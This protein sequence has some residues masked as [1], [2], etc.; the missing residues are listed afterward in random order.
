M[1]F[2]VPLEANDAAND[3]DPRIGGKARS[4][5][6]L[7]AAGL[8]VPRAFAITTD[9]F[10]RLRAG[11]PPL[12]AALDGDAALAAVDDAVAA[13]HAAA[14]PAGFARELADA[15]AGLAP[16]TSFSIRSS[17]E[18]EDHAD[19]LGAGI[20]LSRTDVP[21]SDVLPAVR[22]VLAAALAPAA[23]AYVA[24]RAQGD[25][26]SMAVLVHPFVPG[27]AS[28]TAAF[29][30]GPGDEAGPRI[31]GGE[32]LAPEA[33]ARIVAALRQLAARDGACEVEWVATG[34]DVTFLQLRPYR[35]PARAQPW[36]GA[37]ALADGD[38]A[39]PWT[40][41]A[42]HNP[43]PLSPAQAGL[44]AYVDERCRTPFRQR[45]VEGYL[46]SR[47]EASPAA[48]GDAGEAFATWARDAEA[49]LATL[50]AAS[51][52]EE[53]LAVFAAIYEPLFAR[54]QPAARAARDALAAF[55]RAHGARVDV[56]TLLRGV[57]SLATARAARAEAIAT[58]GEPG[59]RD[60]AVAA[61]VAAFGDEAP[62]WD[63][64]AST[65]AEDPAPLRD[66]AAR[67]PR[68]QTP[69]GEDVA[70]RLDAALPAAARAEGRARLAAA[71]IAAALAE[72]DDA[73][74]ARAQ[75]AVR[76]ALLR[77]GRRLHSANVLARAEDVFSL[78]LPLVRADAR[79]EAPLAPALVTHA[80][81]DARRAHDDARA[82]PPPLPGALAHETGGP[83]LGTVR[84][85]A[86][87]GG[88]A[89]GRVHLHEPGGRVPVPT[90]AVL[91][92][93]TLLPTELPLLSP[94]AIVVE[95][96][97]PLGHVA[98]QARERALPAVVDAPGASTAFRAGDLVLVDGDTGLAIRLAD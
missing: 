21:A 19:A 60:A 58:A 15:L 22:D 18:I 85:R 38:A 29:A 3:A 90:G 59:E 53:A 77:E 68:A 7:A 34:R 33:R 28:G 86:A 55:V 31:E 95:T 35:A 50:S 63:V 83:R 45:V 40:W 82:A 66:L 1:T 93:R 43:L 11:G 88:R 73:L 42:A 14:L 24:R 70:A 67:A 92:A 48:P 9:L 84:G 17:A 71:R 16:A 91:V 12:P 47:P 44:V 64:A 78:P 74:Y 96:G 41:D 36:R 87:S 27:D 94:A 51:S 6:R 69:E 81:A 75:T 39:S 61:Y 89:V 76:H 62:T 54:V 13:L 97:G 37:A 10:Q 5:R 98:A 30:P 65:Y 52:L 4:L 49:A 79:G 80:L 20:F 2:C 8:P 32:A 25:A 26:T 46:F 56:A 72:N 23:L 57:P